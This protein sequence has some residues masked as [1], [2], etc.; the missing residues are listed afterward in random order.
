[1][2]RGSSAKTHNIFCLDKDKALKNN[3][4]GK[5][6][7][8]KE[9]I[10]KIMADCPCYIPQK[11]ISNYDYY[12][13]TVFL[14]FFGETK[15]N[16]RLSKFCS[17][18]V[19]STEKVVSFKPQMASSVM[20][21]CSEKNI[22]IVTTGQGFRVVEKF[23]VT[24][25]GLKVLSAYYNHVKISAVDT[26][27]MSGIVHSNKTIYS[28]EVDFIDIDNLDTIFKEV[29]G[30]LFDKETVHSLLQLENKSKKNSM[31]I[32]A[33]NYVQF[34][35]S[36]DFNKLLYLLNKIDDFDLSKMT[37]RFNLILPLDPKKEKKQIEEN[38]EYVISSV[39]N[40]IKEQSI[41]EFDV[42]HKDT[43]TF[44]SADSYDILCGNKLLSSSD[45]CCS[46]ELFKAAY[47]EYLTG[48]ENKYEV[49]KSFCDDAEINANK[50]DVVITNGRLL[51]YLSGE[52]TVNGIN[53]YMFYGKY[54][55]LNSSYS[56][57]LCATLKTK[58]KP[59]MFENILSTIWEP[60]FD[61]N[62]FNNAASIKDGYI[63]LHLTKPD[64]IEFADLLKL[65]N[66]VAT[67]IHVKDGF[68]C[69]MRELE[70]QVEMSM[71]RLNDLKSNNNDEYMRKLYQNGCNNKAGRNINDFFSTEQEFLDE[72]KKC[73]YKYIIALRINTTNKD[74]L[75]SESN[76]AKHCLN[77]L[78]L[79]CFNRGID[80][81]I[82][83][84]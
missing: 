72:I 22:F 16:S 28:N 9:I 30:R 61:E 34:S 23:C 26:N 41:R 51:D 64:N 24:K 71:V 42:F 1:M 55:L 67:I 80:L 6:V 29:T 48:S 40:Y 45:D 65:E 52:L 58:L 4:G 77:S 38:S 8:D 76:I 81:K 3:F 15:H 46:F 82:N 2:A 33:K 14:Y 27:G 66:G 49:F 19:V 75:K 63:H 70:R 78:I 43:N 83:I 84:L 10:Q 13:F 21:I 59:T 44:I 79:K 20:F 57:R 68:N 7:S 53:Y 62:D 69:T 74:L 37:D 39:Y 56:Q 60:T 11:L 35:S 25:F 18:F 12:G 73:D 47:S 32:I 50:D 17:P 54:Y 31:K 36:L 5:E